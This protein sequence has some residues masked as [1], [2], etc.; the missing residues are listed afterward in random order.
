MSQIAYQVRIIFRKELLDIRKNPNVMMMLLLPLALGFLYT[1]MFEGHPEEI[2]SL[3]GIVLLM[4]LTM[5]SMVTL[6]M[7]IAE[8]KE[9]NTMRTLLLS[10]VQPASF[11]LGKLLFTL[12]CSSV[13]NTIIFLMFKAPVALLPGF[14][15]LSLPLSICMLLIGALIGIYAKN[16]MST[17]V[18]GAPIGM[19][20]LVGPLLSM[21]N[22]NFAKVASLMPSYQTLKLVENY[23]GGKSTF[24][25]LTPW[26]V[27]GTWTLLA[28]IAFYF[29]YQK[30]PIQ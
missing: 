9:K 15:L 12:I 3:I 20:M 22:A 29:G 16:Q 8:E 18:L 14:I 30:R 7:L 21:I 2:T 10:G 27:I 13:V 11:L 6:S 5:C 4:N 1:F 17:G 25:S 26:L 19:I 24:N 23:L 28:Y